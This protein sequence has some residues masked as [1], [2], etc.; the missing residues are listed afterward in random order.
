MGA[1][2]VYYRSGTT[3]LQQGPELDSTGTTGNSSRGLGVAISAD[4]NT[5]IVGG[6]LDNG[7]TG[8]VW[9]YTLGAP[10]I[11]SF[12]PASGPVGTLVTING[13]NLNQS[14]SLTI[15]GV[16]AIVLSQAANS[17]VAMV[18]PGSVN[19]P[20]SLT[21]VAGTGVSDTFFRVTPTP[22]PIVQEGSKKIGTGATGNAAQ[23]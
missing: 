20:I 11:Y 22:F 23:G 12:T 2:W 19:G 3:W 16:P 17:V 13:I 15:G 4:G 21:T 10:Q 18:M 8:A 14:S 5:G 7:E 1:A 6:P 9:F